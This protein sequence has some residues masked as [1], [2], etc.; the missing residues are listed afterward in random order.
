MSGIRKQLA[1]H[2][3]RTRLRGELEDARASQD[4]LEA[5]FMQPSSTIGESQA[6]RAAQARERSSVL[7]KWVSV[8]GA[9]AILGVTV[10]PRVARWIAPSAT[11]QTYTQAELKQL[12][13]EKFTFQPGQ[14]I[15]DAIIKVDGD[16]DIFSDGPDLAAI[17]GFVAGQ[18]PGGTPQPN[19]TVHVPVIPQTGK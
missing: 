19:E 17:E 2:P 11:G 4:A 3:S 18:T 12:P 6:R 13:Q 14:G 15:D 9:T 1:S 7:W 16:K 8:L 5:S 10:A